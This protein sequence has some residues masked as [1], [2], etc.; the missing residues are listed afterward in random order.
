M[1]EELYYQLMSYF[2][3]HGKEFVPSEGDKHSFFIVRVIENE[4]RAAVQIGLLDPE[5]GGEYD[6]D[7]AMM[8][9]ILHKEGRQLMI[10][11]FHQILGGEI[12]RVLKLNALMCDFVDRLHDSLSPD[13]RETFHSLD[14]EAK[15]RLSRALAAK[16][17]SMK[18][19]KD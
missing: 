11:K 12:E 14:R 8:N 17:E 2:M 9:A 15:L 13:E 1:N 10:G 5:M 16:I 6:H 4:D 19:D 7:V 3:E 18:N